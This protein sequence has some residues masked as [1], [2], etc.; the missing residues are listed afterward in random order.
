MDK[1]LDTRST[2]FL[3]LRLKKDCEEVTVC[4][5]YSAAKSEEYSI[6]YI[7][8]MVLSQRAYGIQDFTDSLVISPCLSVKLDDHYQ[9]LSLWNRM[10]KLAEK[11]NIFKALSLLKK[12]RPDYYIKKFVAIKKNL[13]AIFMSFK[14]DKKLN[15]EVL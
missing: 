10:I 1:R 3:D 11:G 5:N 4:G 8:K 9:M 14:N 13:N 6:D 12:E 7:I 2:R 15:R